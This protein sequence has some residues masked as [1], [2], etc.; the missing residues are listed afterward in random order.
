MDTQ[1]K[2]R[3]IIASVTGLTQD[4]SADANLY[5]DLGVASV[6]A[7]HLLNE[8]EQSFGVGIPDEEYVKATS[9]GKLTALV[10][11]LTKTGT[12]QDSASA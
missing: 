10:D 2:I 5:L 12:G 3:E 9:V 11:S 4:V 6:H 1:T 8:L 7:L